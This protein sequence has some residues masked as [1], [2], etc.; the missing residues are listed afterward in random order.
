MRLKLY[1]AAGIAEAMAR[2]RAEMGPD[3]LILATRRVIDGVEVTAALEP[4]EPGPAPPTLDPGRTAALAFHGV[5]LHLREALQ[6]GPLAAA[7]RGNL[8]FAALPLDGGNAPLLLAGPPGA[9]KT[10]TI[11][12]LATRL[13]M[14]GVAPMVVTADG[15]R[16]GATEQLA[17]F[18]RLL[19]LNLL[20]ASHPVTLG[21]ALAR[22][23]QGA[24]VLIDTAGLD[25]YDPGQREELMALAAT[26]G[27]LVALVL[28]AGM[29]PEEAADLGAAFA[30]AGATLLIATRVDLARRLG[31]VLSA[32]AAG[33]LALAEAGIGP[34]VADGL[35]PL[36]PDFLAG[37]LLAEAPGPRPPARSRSGPQSPAGAEPDPQPLP[38]LPPKASARSMAHP[39]RRP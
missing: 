24:P 12:R 26:A 32:S 2:V 11:A 18:T 25:P 28:P 31:S 22:R 10:L 7:L 20:V 6:S 16:A 8:A 13:V 35:T 34:G 17:A 30:A 1:R 37:R 29:D 3:A 5:P 14:A 38:W 27:A 33:R 9:G 15:S 19:R 36:T 4:A 23:A 21:R 39:E